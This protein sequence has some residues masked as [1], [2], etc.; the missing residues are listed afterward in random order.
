MLSGATYEDHKKLIWHYANRVWRRAQ[1]AGARTV[2]L[3]DIVSELSVAWVIAVE[4]FND[5]NGVPFVPYLRNGMQH[6]IN[7]WIEKEIGQANLMVFGDALDVFAAVNPTVEADIAHDQYRRQV[8]N[9]LAPIARKVLELLDN[10]P[11]PLVAELRALQAK[12]DWSRQRGFNMT[13]P[14]RITTRM[15]TD[16]M[17]LTQRQR[18]DVSRE[19]KKIIA[20][21][22]KVNQ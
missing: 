10:P 22:D 20:F 2:Q 15:I 19:F 14:G 9:S 4:N 3:E 21:S 7:R 16:L 18:E 13:A 6:H 12:R 1:A 17:G 11:E 8:S 5:N